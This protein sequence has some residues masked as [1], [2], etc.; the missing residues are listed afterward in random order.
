MNCT[1][2]G[3][4][5]NLYCLVTEKSVV[6]YHLSCARPCQ[7]LLIFSYSHM[8]RIAHCVARGINSVTLVEQYSDLGAL[9]SP[10]GSTK[11]PGEFS[12]LNAV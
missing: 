7:R 11:V 6:F 9:S 1:D 2:C 10:T 8:K 5:T 3:K 4:A 12:P